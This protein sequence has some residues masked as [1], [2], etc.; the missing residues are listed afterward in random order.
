MNISIITIYF[1]Q[2]NFG[3]R[4]QN[5]ALQEYLRKLG[6]Q[7]NTIVRNACR[8]NPWSPFRRF[9]DKYMNIRLVDSERDV[10]EHDSDLFV[11]GSDQVFSCRWSY[12]SRDFYTL[13]HIPANKKICYSASDGENFYTDL[14]IGGRQDFFNKICTIGSLSFREYD[15]YKTFEA[16][17]LPQTVTYNI[18]P[19]FLL[20]KEDWIK[21]E[22][23]PDNVGEDE[24]FDISYLLGSNTSGINVQNEQEKLKNQ[25]VKVYEL[26]SMGLAPDEFIWMYHHCRK[27]YTMSF[28]GVAFSLIF[29]KPCYVY[30]YNDFRISNIFK[31]LKIEPSNNIFP[32]DDVFQNIEFEVYRSHKYL[33]SKL[34][35]DNCS[36]QKNDIEYCAYSKQ[37]RDMS[38]SG[39]ICA[40]LAKKWFDRGG[41][42]YGASYSKDFRSVN[43][44][45]VNNMLDYYKNISG[46]KYSFSKMPKF[47]EIKQQLD[48]NM[49]I[50]FIGLPC[51]VKALSKYLDKK[52]M[53]LLLVELLCSGVS[54]NDRLA[55]IIDQIESNA[56]SKVISFNMRYK[57]KLICAY[58]FE[59]GFSGIIPQIDSYHYFID[60]CRLPTCQKCTLHMGSGYSDI[61]VGDFWNHY[62]NGRVNDGKFS[63]EIGTNIVYIHSERGSRMFDSIKNNIDFKQI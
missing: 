19:V 56:N 9:D 46:S 51:Q 10:K 7:V 55:N 25:D 44:I 1:D 15:T 33:K 54:S 23:K 50:M 26:N 62:N 2:D 49:H 41:I 24:V 5:Y 34:N 57:H 8:N 12:D 30:Y 3:Q 27:A 20:S 36:P 48:Q 38:T 29:R 35:Q 4:L 43:I 31:I 60:S 17:G 11:I 14:S 45:P 6:H 28:H 32:T 22:K 16:K 18:D 63:P 58:T 37:A 61:T 13:P 52:H 53:N 59:N 21:I 39:G 42:V 40:E 47:N